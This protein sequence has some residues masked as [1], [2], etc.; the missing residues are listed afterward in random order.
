MSTASRTLKK[1]RW[2]PPRVEAVREGSPCEGAVE[3]GDLL[4]EIGG[5]HPLDVLDVLY[6]GAEGRVRLRLRRGG[7]ELTRVIRKPPEQPLSLLFDRAVFDGVRRCAN[8]CVFCFVDQ[9]PPG[10]RASLY[11]KDDDYRLSFL[12]GNFITLNNLSR[13]DVE[14]IRKIRISPLYVSLHATRP[15]L[16][17]ELMGAGA[18]RG[19]AVLRELMEAGLEVHLQVVVCP[20]INDGDELERTFRDVLE[21]YDNASSL[22]A[23]PVGLTRFAHRLPRPL[24]AHDSHSAAAVLDLVEEF[25]ALA[26][27]RTGRRLFFAADEFYL[28]AGREFPPEEEYEDYPQLE[29]G[30]GMARKFLE[31]AARAAREGGSHAPR[32]GVLTGT[33]GAAVLERA[34]K[35]AETGA[36]LVRVRNLLLG[37]TVTVSG[38]LA[39]RDVISALREAPPSCGELLLPETALREGRFLDDLTPLEV[40]GATGFRIVPCPVDGGEFLGQLAG[41]RGDGVAR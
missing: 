28:L 26:L 31:E 1:S 7:R 27:E 6:L 9:M 3:E 36:E 5:R 18:E 34:L 19:L 12:H 32:R 8:R 22:A 2:S 29:N 41:E 20:G 37:E 11:L 25:Q 24:R 30:V 40:E 39:G 15:S 13:G 38:L 4:L 14:R 35:E 33:L 17:A 21:D 10:L 16:R 23:V